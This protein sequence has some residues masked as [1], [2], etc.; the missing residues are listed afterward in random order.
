MGRFFCDDIFGAPEFSIEIDVEFNA[1]NSIIAV[2]GIPIPKDL[3]V[4]Y[5]KDLTAIN[6]ADISLCPEISASFIAVKS[7]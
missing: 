3:S 5:S 4:Y 1:T 2:A 6:E 7:L